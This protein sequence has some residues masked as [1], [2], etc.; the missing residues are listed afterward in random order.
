MNNAY[1][2]HHLLSCFTYIID[3]YDGTSLKQKRIQPQHFSLQN[4]QAQK[5]CYHQ[6]TISAVDILHQQHAQTSSHFFAFK[7]MLLFSYLVS[8]F[9]STYPQE[10]ESKNVSA[11]RYTCS[12][13]TA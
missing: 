11:A 13:Y 5:Q 6:K 3:V 8:T 4:L 2:Q 9:C 1:I 12:T 10:V 7:K